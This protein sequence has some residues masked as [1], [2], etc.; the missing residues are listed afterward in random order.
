MEN[1]LRRALSREELTLHYQPIVDLRTGSLAGMEALV[2][3]AHPEK[4]LLGPSE[5]LWLAEET[6]LIVAIGEWALHAA[7]KRQRI[8]HGMG[9]PA[10]RVAV[11]LSYKQFVPRNLAQIVRSTLQE[12]ELEACLLKLEITETGLMQDV[13]R[14]N[15]TLLELGAMGVE[16]AIDDFGTGYS[17]LSYLKSLP[18]DSLKVDRSFVSGV[19]TDVDDDAIVTA[20]IGLAHHLGLRVIAEGIETRQQL[21]RL[22]Q[23]E[24][25][26]GQG[27]YF[28]PPVPPEE[29]EVLLHAKM[30]FAAV[31][32]KAAGQPN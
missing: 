9:L 2:R 25:D 32:G 21:A 17:S 3:W 12:N 11:N 15:D 31:I 23:Q 18:I 1:A 6:G 30:P 28:S 14:A 8:W 24:C 20:T 16:V 19:A 4:G 22:V 26:E 5:F 13:A 29:M 7:C 27:Y 10:P